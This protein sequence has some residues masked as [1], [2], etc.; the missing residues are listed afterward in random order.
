[1]PS[2]GVRMCE[3]NIKVSLCVCN[4]CLL[5]GKTDKMAEL[6]ETFVTCRELLRETADTVR[7][8]E[9]RGGG[10]FSIPRRVTVI[11]WELFTARLRLVCITCLSR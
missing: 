4:V 2:V 7:E 10:G 3:D 8:E 6:C 11:K 5:G 9:R 1:M